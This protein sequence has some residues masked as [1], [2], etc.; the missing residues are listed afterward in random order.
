MRSF[1]FGCAITMC[2]GGS[3]LAQV[4]DR[5]AKPGATAT[6]DA[7]T[8]AAGWNALAAGRSDAAVMEAETILKRRPW[9]R[10][11]ILLKIHAL[12]SVAPLRGLDAYEEWLAARHGEDVGFLEPA[13]IGIVQEIANTRDPEVQRSALRALAAA[14]VVGSQ[15]RLDA[16][17]PSGDGAL[18]RDVEAARAGDVTA[19]QRLNDRAT[20][21]AGGTPGLAKALADIGSAGQPGLLLLLTSSQPQTRAAA[22]EALGPMKLDA[23]RDA[24]TKLLQDSDPVVRMSATISLA[25]MGDPAALATA[26]RM[27]AGDVPDVQLAAARAWEGRPGPWVEVV[28]SLLAN[29][30][31]VTRLEAAR[32]I[33]PVDPEA[34]RK[35]LGVALG[36]ANPVIRYESARVIDEALT[37]HLL[38]TD[39]VTLRQ[40]LR[41]PDL[42]VRLTVAGVLLRLARP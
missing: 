37:D 18:D 23:A 6:P 34:A 42:A 27:L 14:R 28:R 8:I 39:V 40:R 32:A 13:V 16:L 21:P 7:A 15:E 24:L 11:A 35:V 3:A 26:D 25:Q 22:A 12:T 41:D 4:R 38:L 20:T 9:D 30:D 29:P 36:D 1:F 10:S 5:T 31:G 17:N 2:L 33:A 19:L